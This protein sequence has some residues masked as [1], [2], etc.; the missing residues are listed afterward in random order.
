[1]QVLTG[2]RIRLNTGVDLSALI[3]SQA[4]EGGGGGRAIIPSVVP[5]AL[6]LQISMVR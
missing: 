4:G 5:C 2:A 3:I 1:M 6:A